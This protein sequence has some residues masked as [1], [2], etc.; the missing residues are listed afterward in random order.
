ME[1]GGEK[2]RRAEKQTEPGRVGQEGG[3]HPG[4]TLA[5]GSRLSPDWSLVDAGTQERCQAH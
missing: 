4:W 5:P 2:K 1:T 3:E